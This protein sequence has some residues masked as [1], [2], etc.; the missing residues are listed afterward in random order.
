MTSVRR[1]SLVSVLVAASLGAAVGCGDN[2]P[3][4]HDGGAGGTGGSTMNLD[5]NLEDTSDSGDAADGGLA[6]LA[7]DADARD[8]SDDVSLE[9]SGDGPA[10]CYTVTFTDPV[11]LSLLT[12]DDDKDGDNCVNGFQ[13]DVHIAT[14][15]PDGTDV[16]LYAGAAALDTAVVSNG[17]AT[18]VHVQLPTSGGTDLSV[19][20]PSTLPCDG[21]SAKAHVTVSC[22]QPTCAITSPTISPT[23]P[24]LNGEPRDEG[25]D[26]ASA[27]FAPYQVAFEVATDSSGVQTVELDVVDPATPT[28]VT[29]LVAVP[30]AGK[31]VF[32]VPLSS[33][34]NYSIQARCT[35]TN[36]AQGLSGKGSYPVD[37][38]SPPLTITRPQ[39]GAFIGPM[40]LVSGAFPVCGTTTADDAVNLDPALGA[41]V[42]NFCVMSGGV[43][44][45][46]PARQTGTEV[47][48]SVSCLGEAAFDVTTTLTDAAGNVQTKT[49][50]D[51]TCSASFPTIQIV[52]PLSG[53]PAFTDTSRHLLAATA[54][55][56]FHDLDGVAAGAQTNVVACANRAGTA[57]LF[58]GLKTDA[59][60]VQVGTTTETRAAVPA[61]GCPSGFQ[62]AVTFPGVTLPE[63]PQGADTSPVTP[64]VLRADLTDRSMA[65]KSSPVVELWVDSIAPV[66][67]LALDLCG[68]FHQSATTYVSSETVTSTAPFV[69]LVLMDSS[70]TQNFNSST[71]PASLTFLVSFSQ[72]QT[73]LSGVVRDAA[74]N[75]SE[76]VPKPCVVT[77]A[78]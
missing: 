46:A 58:T 31:A 16:S 47:C 77:V 56:A 51:L 69:S 10:T 34:T 35:A 9:A 24:A 75:E 41:R 52:S 4:L 23:H 44:A 18:F 6:D 63:S 39:P 53:S 78:P 19:Q 8:A 21:P 49:L 73:F 17:K 76:A 60:L 67:Q 15:A 25:G 45:C 50:E 62:F 12:N 1:R 36:H 70:S 40:G 61:D 28:V 43:S 22:T 30:N 33:A 14:A 72:G 5:G 71:F 20:F 11:N 65:M 54:P 59:A 64:T 3:A 42:S 38:V 26:R 66:L 68:A 48:V 57:K 32:M 37:I 55:Q 74:G 29:T 13:H 2:R 27:A 7:P